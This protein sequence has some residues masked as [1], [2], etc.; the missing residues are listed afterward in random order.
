MAAVGAP[1]APFDPN[2]YPLL[3]VSCPSP[4]YCLAAGGRLV[5]FTGTAW[6]KS[7][8][9]DG[10][11]GDAT[12]CASS[13]FCALLRST[14]GLTFNGRAWKFH[15]FT[16]QPFGSGI[17][18]VSLSCPS[19]DFCAAVG[20]QNVGSGATIGTVAT[21]DGRSWS[22][23]RSITSIDG[24]DSVSCRSRWFCVAADYRGDVVTYDGLSWSRPLSVDP[25]PNGDAYAWE[26]SYLGDAAPV[27]NSVSCATF[28][29]CAM[30]DVNGNAVT[31]RAPDLAIASSRLTVARGTTTVSLSCSDEDPGSTCSG[32]LT[33]HASR[34]RRVVRRIHGHRRTRVVTQ[35]VLLA[36]TSYS[37][38]SSGPSQVTVTLTKPG[39]RML[40]TAHHRRLQAAA[41]ATLEGGGASTAPSPCGSRAEF[42]PEV[43]SADCLIERGFRWESA[44]ACLRRPSHCS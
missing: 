17:T 35:V 36:E 8:Q 6:S 7:L 21:Y 15:S 12:S 38:P 23:L 24:L 29:F 26:Y 41:T 3:S 1:P 16:A 2:S 34:T 13:S 18:L 27:D 11:G 25:I 30:T 39:L 4:A 20:G 43:H 9:I 40:R 28:S 37:L 31:Y 10:G 14:A 44:E 33:L 5:S 22:K 19:R 42:L 32:A